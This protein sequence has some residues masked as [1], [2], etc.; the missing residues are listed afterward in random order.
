[1]SPIQQTLRSREIPRPT[2]IRAFTG[3]RSIKSAVFDA[4]TL[5]ATTIS[6]PLQYQNI[7]G[8]FL[9]TIQAYVLPIGTFLGESPN[10]A[11]KVSAYTGTGS[12]ANDV[13]TLTTTGT[14]TGGTYTLTFNGATTTNIAFNSTSTVLQAA[15]VALPTIGATANVTV[16]GGAFP[17]TPLV[18]TFGGLLGNLPQPLITANSSGLTGGT[19]PVVT[20]VHTTP[21][22][23]AQHLLGVFDGPDR[24]FFGNVVGDNEAIPMYFHECVFDISKLPN[25][26]QYGATAKTSLPTCDWY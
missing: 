25:W 19:T 7:W 6:A 11:T 26:F 20:P 9:Q 12:N 14:P 2:C 15:L 24:D 5:T 21:G 22:T 18:V 1:M 16:T 4:S 17:G 23:F 8:S 13:Q 3:T 10:D